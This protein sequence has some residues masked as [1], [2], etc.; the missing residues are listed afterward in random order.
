MVTQV[1]KA[2]LIQKYKGIKGPKGIPGPEGIKYPKG[3]YVTKE[4][5]KQK[6]MK[7]IIDALSEAILATGKRFEEIPKRSITDYLDKVG[8]NKSKHEE[9]YQKLNEIYNVAHV[10]PKSKSDVSKDKTP[11]PVTKV[12]H[13]H[14]VTAKTKERQPRKNVFSEITKIN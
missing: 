3:W 8:V 11:S 6:N 7:E 2:E 5:E 10:K 4:Q 9:I 12:V 14:A 13:P 1:T